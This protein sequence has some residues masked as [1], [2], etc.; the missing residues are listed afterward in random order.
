VSLLP[1]VVHVGTILS[2][3]DAYVS[4]SFFE[5][6]SIAASEAAWNGLPL[7]LSDCGS[8]RELVGERGER[9]RVVP[10]PLG[11]PLDVTWERLQAHPAA[12]V[13]GNEQALAGALLDV[14]AERADWISRREDILHHART[15]VAPDRVSGAYAEL[16]KRAL[17]S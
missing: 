17:A 7:V 1:P 11:D 15:E 16:F 5:G 2:A 12:P 8:A 9:G 4:D 14:I 10:N 3:A 6:W 13:A